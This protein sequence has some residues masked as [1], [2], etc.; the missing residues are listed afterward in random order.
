MANVDFEISGSFDPV[1]KSLQAT[2]VAAREFASTEKKV[3]ESFQADI[4]KSVAEVNKLEAATSGAGEALASLAVSSGALA[5]AGST[6]EKQAAGFAK[7]GEVVDAMD[8]NLQSLI[9]SL[10]D[11]GLAAEAATVVA[12][13]A[14]SKERAALQDLIEARLQA[15]EANKQDELNSAIGAQINKIKELTAAFEQLA[16]Q[17][18]VPAQGTAFETL[19]ERFRA[20]Q[21]EARELGASLGT[22]D[23]KFIEAAQRADE[24]QRSI[25]KISDAIEAVNSLPTAGVDELIKSLTAQGVAADQASTVVTAALNRE[26]AALQALT[27]ERSQSA[28]PTKQIELNN[29][30]NEGADNVRKLS[31]ELERLATIDP[32]KA[33]VSGFQRLQI[34]IRQAEAEAQELGIAYGQLDP[35]FITAAQKAA[36]LKEELQD[37]RQTIDALNPEAKFRAFEAVTQGLIGSFQILTG[38]LQLFGVESEKVQKIAMQFQG[39]LNFAQGVNSLFGLRDSFKNLAITMGLSTKAAIKD[40]VVKTTQISTTNALTG[41][42]VTETTVTKAGT[43]ATNAWTAAFLKNPIGI[44]LIATLAL[45]E[46][47]YQ[48]VDSLETAIEKEL[49]LNEERIKNYEQ[50]NTAQIESLNREAKNLELGITAEKDAALKKLKARIISEEDYDKELQKIE[51]KRAQIFLDSANAAIKAVKDASPEL[52]QI[53]AEAEAKILAIDERAFKQELAQESEQQS[54]RK[55]LLEKH[56]KELEAL[57]TRLSEKATSAILNSITAEERIKAERKLALDELDKLISDIEARQGKPLSNKQLEQFSAILTEIEQRTNSKLNELFA[58]RGKILAKINLQDQ[59]AQ[60][61]AA[62]EAG[63]NKRTE[64]LRKIGLTEVQIIEVVN[65]ERAEINKKGLDAQLT[66]GEE[67]AKALVEQQALQAK[68]EQSR[69]IIRQRGLL[70]IQIQFA[71]ARLKLLEGDSSEEAA[72]LRVKLQNAIQ[73]AQNQLNAVAQSGEKFSLSKLFGLTLSPEDE[74]RFNQAVGQLVGNIQE[75]Y[76]SFFSEQQAALDRQKEQNEALKESLQERIDVTEEALSRELQLQQ[77]GYDANVEGKRKELEMLNAEKAAA[78]N[79][80]KKI[81][82]EQEKLQRQQ[83][84]INSLQQASSL[85]VAGAQLFASESTKGVAG[86][87]IAISALALLTGAFL[88]FKKAAAQA[89]IQTFGEGGEIKGRSHAQGG[90]MIEAEGREYMVQKSEA[91]KRDRKKVLQAINE[92]SFKGLKFDDLRFML[93]GAGISLN[94]EVSEELTSQRTIIQNYAATITNNINEDRLATKIAQKQIE[95]QRKV[96]YNKERKNAARK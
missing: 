27:V 5:D 87:V 74:A 21:D 48:Y 52:L 23:P 71:Q 15:T 44:I 12:V 22:L 75:I 85:A 86:I 18:V 60:E 38:T 56:A 55:A 33:Q 79:R 47:I 51:R 93:E 62:F 89:S 59:Q 88:S 82:A 64:E 63:L 57:T 16:A 54:K 78:L 3:N 2:T 4:K 24:L 53:K 45:T 69:E 19:L 50:V 31:V 65:A 25:L 95:A 35:R 42:I 81:Q 36:N 72:L 67:F 96:D 83:I 1:T 61:L 91:Q 34:Q 40:T 43:A 11:Q 58:E 46:A 14:M 7:L 84:I 10:V 26:R 6:A 17:D 39:V 9:K 20:A 37:V 41:A 94:P 32:T 29:Q 66:Q 13:T 73:D 77:A 30:I 49:R 68:D 76:A 8:N 92:N 70:N 90:V 28:D 80:D